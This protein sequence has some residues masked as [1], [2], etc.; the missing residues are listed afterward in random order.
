M[1]RLLGLDYELNTRNGQS[2]FNYADSPTSRRNIINNI[3]SRYARNIR[4]TK[5]WAD[6]TNNLMK[7]LRGRNVWYDNIYQ[8]EKARNDRQYSR[9][10]YMGS[11]NG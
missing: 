5:Q 9:R 7:L 8:A 4:N 6:D 11:S 3:Y 2:A 1:R 10:A